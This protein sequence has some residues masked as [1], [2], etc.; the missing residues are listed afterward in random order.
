MVAGSDTWLMGGVSAHRFNGAMPLTL[1]FKIAPAFRQYAIFT[2]NGWRPAPM[3]AAR[4]PSFASYLGTH[5]FGVTPTTL[6]FIG[7]M[8]CLKRTRIPTTLSFARNTP[9]P[10][11]PDFRHPLRQE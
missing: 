2:P 5:N 7:E 11:T 10:F 4:V 8:S 1:N 3:L 9:H 6:H